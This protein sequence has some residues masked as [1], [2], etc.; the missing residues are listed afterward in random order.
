MQALARPLAQLAPSSS[1][2]FSG[3]TSFLFRYCYLSSSD[4]FWCVSVLISSSQRVCGKYILNVTSLGASKTS[5]RAS[6]VVLVVK[7]PL[8]NA[9]DMRCRLDSWVRKVPLEDQG[10]YMDWSVWTVWTVACQAPLSMGFSMD[11]GTCLPGCVQSLS[12]VWLFVTPW[13]AAPQASLSFT[14][15]RNL[16]KLMSTES[17]MPSDHFIFCY[18]NDWTCPRRHVPS[19]PWRIPWTEEPGRLQ[20]VGSQRVGQDWSNL[21]CMHIRPL[22]VLDPVICCPVRHQVLWLGMLKE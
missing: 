10:T 6:Q 7:N 11:M 4:L 2:A 8:A 19:C 16:L 21:A 18:L 22:Q 9:G 5:S 12:R 17:L 13:S 15:S 20:S 3:L 1:E 14:I